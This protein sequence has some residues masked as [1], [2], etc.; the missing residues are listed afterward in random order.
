ML[1]LKVV[2]D[3]MEVFGSLAVMV[4]NVMRWLHVQYG[5]GVEWCSRE[6]VG[7]RA[8]WLRGRVGDARTGRRGG[9]WLRDTVSVA[10]VLLVEGC[11]R[12]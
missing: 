4:M 5:E 2:G 6:W 10:D 9:A 3:P 12:L 8:S 7:R 1:L 11:A